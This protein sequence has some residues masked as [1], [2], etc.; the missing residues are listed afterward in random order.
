MT[1]LCVIIS[2]L[3]TYY[4]IY[5]DNKK[6]VLKPLWAI[7]YSP[8]Q[9]IGLYDMYIFPMLQL[10]RWICY[11]CLH[12]N[13]SDFVKFCTY[14][15]LHRYIRKNQC[16]QSYYHILINIWNSICA[17]YICYFYK[18]LWFIEFLFTYILSQSY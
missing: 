8:W 17:K 14:H 16:S 5:V 6:P 9:T 13:A 11:I 7:P 10:V 18:I 2:R 1:F 4:P 15:M 3:L 12:V